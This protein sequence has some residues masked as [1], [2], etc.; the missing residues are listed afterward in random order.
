MADH[1]FSTLTFPAVFLSVLLNNA[2][3]SGVSNGDKR[4]DCRRYAELP[5]TKHHAKKIAKMKLTG[6]LD[7]MV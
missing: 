1:V 4:I 3:I 5:K 2:L 7:T 6:R